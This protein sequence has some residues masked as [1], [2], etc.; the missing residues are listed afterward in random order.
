[1]GG[2]VWLERWITDAAEPYE[3]ERCGRAV[4]AVMRIKAGAPVAVVGGLVVPI[5]Q[6]DEYR[7]HMT[8]VGLQVNDGFFLCPSDDASIAA[9]GVFNHSCEPNIGLVDSVTFVALTPIEPGADL[10]FDYAFSETHFDGFEC[11]CE[12]PTCRG[13]VEPTDWRDRRI[14]ESYGSYFSPYLQAKFRR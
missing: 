8:H 14:Q 5:E 7:E 4:R 6:I 13:R 10:C 12:A 9:T 2:S 11:L 3:T 1:M